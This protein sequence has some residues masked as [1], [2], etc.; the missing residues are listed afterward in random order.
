M[1]DKVSISE[2]GYLG[3]TQHFTSIEVLWEISLLNLTR[4]LDKY[5]L[6]KREMLCLSHI[7]DA[8]LIN[9]E[10]DLECLMFLFLSNL[11]K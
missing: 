5:T 2:D 6:K 9:C 1:K 8:K 7:Y 11:A 10:P 3:S 4:M